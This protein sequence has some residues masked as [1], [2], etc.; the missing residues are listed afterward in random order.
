MRVAEV[1]L[2]GGYITGKG[3]DLPDG[4]AVLLVRK[5]LELGCNYVDTAPLYGTSRSETCIGLALQGWDGVCH[6]AT[7]VGFHPRD[8]DYSRDA[9]LRSCEAS[10]TRL[11]LDTLD[12]LQIHQCELA[13]WNRIMGPDGALAG[14]RTL[15]RRGIVRYLGITGYDLDLLVRLVRT[16]AFDVVLNY[17][18]YDLLVQEAKRLL[19]PVAARHRVAYVAGGPLH[20]G[21]LGTWREERLASIKDPGEASRTRAR[22]ARLDALLAGRGES[23]S[24]TALRYLLS[25][26]RVAVVIPSAHRLE[27]IEENVTASHAGPLFPDLIAAIEG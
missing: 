4:E 27:Q 19:V 1:G 8:F 7:K 6:V 9:V 11:R 5:A 14:L 13:G 21:L 10:L 12:V 17:N 3:N 23:V 20:G 25:D 2:G 15:Q 16:G 26:P 18:R 22:L 24:R